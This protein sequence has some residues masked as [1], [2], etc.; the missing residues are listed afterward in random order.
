[1]VLI[2]YLNTSK[3]MARDLK[4]LLL[5]LQINVNLH[6]IKIHPTESAKRTHI[7]S[8]GS[9]A[10]YLKCYEHPI[11]KIRVY[12]A[13]FRTRDG[14]VVTRL[15]HTHG[16][17]S[18]EGKPLRPSDLRLYESDTK[19]LIEKFADRHNDIQIDVE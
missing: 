9:Q 8:S 13:A 3:L 16:K 7:H 5:D 12:A 1:M 11:S 14:A 2:L 18:W 15:S 6:L 17:H 10:L 19:T 4:A